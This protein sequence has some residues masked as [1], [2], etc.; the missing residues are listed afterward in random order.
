M[1]FDFHWFQNQLKNFLF[2]KT[3]KT[4]KNKTIIGGSRKVI[5]II[6]IFFILFS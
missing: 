3:I 5:F 4:E 6:C 2:K 1:N